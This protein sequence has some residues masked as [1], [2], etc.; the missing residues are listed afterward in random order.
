MLGKL[1]EYNVDWVCKLTEL[2]LSLNQ[3]IEIPESIGNLTL[4][5][6]LYIYDNKLRSYPI[7]LHLIHLQTLDI[8]F[9]PIPTLTN[10][11][12]FSLTNLTELSM[13]KEE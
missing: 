2:D 13:Q 7:P 8:S 1:A 4:L 12:N 9:Q 3:L 11:I 10:S 6:E 5:T